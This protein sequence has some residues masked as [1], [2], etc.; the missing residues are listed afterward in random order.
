MPRVK[1]VIHDTIE[2]M[3]FVQCFECG[4]VY[5]TKEAI[6]KDFNQLLKELTEH[7]TI[8]NPPIKTFDEAPF[9]PLCLH[10]W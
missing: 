1:C 8:E 2:P 6:V 7:T 3:G 4:H 9:C 5:P 10:D